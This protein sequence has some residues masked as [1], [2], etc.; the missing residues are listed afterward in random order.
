MGRS[1]STQDVGPSFQDIAAV[2]GLDCYRTQLPPLDPVTFVEP[3]LPL[4]LLP[5]VF[6]YNG[7]SVCDTVI[8]NKKYIFGFV[9]CS[10]YRAPKTCDI[11]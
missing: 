7:H 5:C 1:P 9:S 11:S 6:G 10:W 4:D 3:L 8:Y 2:A